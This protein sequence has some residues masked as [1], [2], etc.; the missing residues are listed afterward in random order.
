LARS[1]FL[2]RLAS[3]MSSRMTK[4]MTIGMIQPLPEDEPLPV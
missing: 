4:M 2:L 3:Q 1:G